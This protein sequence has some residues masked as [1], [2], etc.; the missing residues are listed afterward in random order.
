MVLVVE[1]DLKRVDAAIFELRDVHPVDD[2]RRAWRTESPEQSSDVVIAGR[3][4]HRREFELVGKRG[5]K[6]CNGE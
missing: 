5:L 3:E 1:E 4:S 6:R 2:G